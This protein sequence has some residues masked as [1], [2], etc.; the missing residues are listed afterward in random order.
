MCE[1]SLESNFQPCILVARNFHDFVTNFVESGPS[2]IAHGI[3]CGYTRSH[4]ILRPPLV[5]DEFY[6]LVRI[7]LERM[8][9]QGP[10]PRSSK[11]HFPGAFISVRN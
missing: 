2:A 7:T 9:P 5:R 8:T 3:R 6:T 1:E 4:G 10:F 11:G